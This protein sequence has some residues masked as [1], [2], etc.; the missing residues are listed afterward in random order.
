MELQ[1]DP[2]MPQI[3]KGQLLLYLKNNT[4]VRKIAILNASSA[5]PI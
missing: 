2:I 3:Y 4:H 5:K 1:F